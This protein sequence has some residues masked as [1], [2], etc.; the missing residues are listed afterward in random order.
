MYLGDAEK[1]WAVDQSGRTATHLCRRAS[2]DRPFIF[3][4]TRSQTV[5]GSHSA[6]D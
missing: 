3:F 5:R 2:V 6:Q 1:H 4:G